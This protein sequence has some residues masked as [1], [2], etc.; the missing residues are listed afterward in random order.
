MTGSTITLQ[1]NKRKHKAIMT[2][3]SMAIKRQVPV[4]AGLMLKADQ[5]IFPIG[6]KDDHSLDNAVLQHM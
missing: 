2:A 5:L 4:V 6:P 3:I 1:S